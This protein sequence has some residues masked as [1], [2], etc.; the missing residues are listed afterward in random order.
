MK[1][2]DDC[3]GA[4]DFIDD[5]IDKRLAK[6]GGGMSKKEEIRRMREKHDSRN[7]RLLGITLIFV[8]LLITLAANPPLFFKFLGAFLNLSLY[9][10]AFI[11]FIL[12]IA[13][14]VTGGQK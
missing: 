3:D 10:I 2:Y 4:Q 11:I 6:A 7:A 1:S 14:L 9:I 5:N 8:S 12:G 13:L